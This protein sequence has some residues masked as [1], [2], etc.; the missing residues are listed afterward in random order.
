LMR[1]ASCELHAR[2]LQKVNL[3]PTVGKTI[4][5]TDYLGR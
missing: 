1:E 5:S 4:E 3:S 2:W